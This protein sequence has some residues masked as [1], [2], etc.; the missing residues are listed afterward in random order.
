MPDKLS[1]INDCL[2]LKGQRTVNTQDDGSDE[3]SVCSAAYDH[4]VKHLLE[5]HD[6][7]FGTHIVSLTRTGDAD[8][9]NYADAYAKPVGALHLVWVRM[10]DAA[11]DYRIVGGKVLINAGGGEV[12]AK[13]VTEPGPEDWPAMFISA[14]RELI[15]SGIESG[16]KKNTTDARIHQGA[17]DEFL[18][19]AKTRTDQ[20]EPKR[21]LFKGRHRTA[22]S[23]RRG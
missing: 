19:R 7:K 10:E 15:F 16:I 23:S 2:L 12:T 13:V 18:R 1:I 4:A 3:W 20:E 11:A 17:A 9:A 5:E 14:L 21:T 22:R 8:D 6:W